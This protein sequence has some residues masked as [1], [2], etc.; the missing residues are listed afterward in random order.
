MIS[1]EIGR[2]NIRRDL[3]TEAK[4][5]LENSVSRIDLRQLESIYRQATD[6]VTGIQKTF[7]ELCNFHNQMIAEK[8]SYIAQTTSV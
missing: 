5:D 6:R 8:V 1:T 7:E 4:Q 2:L 3:I